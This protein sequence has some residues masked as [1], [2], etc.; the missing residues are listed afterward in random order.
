MDRID[1][2]IIGAGVVGLATARALALA[3]KT[4]IVL[5]REARFGAGTSS[6]NSEV[7]HAGIHYPHGSLKER[8]CIEGKRRLYEYCAARHLPHRRCGKLTVAGEESERARLEGIAVH[9][10]ESGADAELRWLEGGEVAGIEPAIRCAAAL[11][12]PSSGIVDSHALMLSLLGEA[13]D[14]GA[15]LACRSPVDRVT[16]SGGWWRVHVG[17]TRL[18]AQIVVN[19]A[20]LDAWAVAASIEALEARHIPPRFLAKGSYFSYAGKVPF[21]RLIYPLPMKGGLGTHL[22]LDMAGQARFGPDV[23]WVDRVDY[24]VDPARKPAFLASVRRFWPRIDAEKL[25]PGYSG[26]RPKI[27]GPAEPDE[28][29]LLQGEAA[30]GQPGLVNLFGIDSPGLTS[31]LAIGERVA[32]MC[33]QGA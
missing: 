1:A 32:K 27:A 13:E 3:G 33:L 18:E 22:T 14:R 8:L 12:S 28:D 19:A 5:E 2:A 16:R 10:R 17:E 7:I 20:G 9:A 4:V 11:L 6:R 23:E 15:V 26:V 29:F 30:H 25:V 21:T 24:A 31:S